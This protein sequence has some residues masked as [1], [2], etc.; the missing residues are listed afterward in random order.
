MPRITP[1]HRT[2]VHDEG[3]WSTVWV[4]GSGR[5]L[6]GSVDECVKV[7]EDGG[8]ALQFVHTYQ[9]HSLGVVSVVA[10]PGAELAAASALDSTVRIW[11]LSS[12]E[13]VSI[14]ETVSTETWSICF[15]PQRDV[16]QLAAAAGTRASVVLWGLLVG[17]NDTEMQA[18]LNLPQVRACGILCLPRWIDR[19]EG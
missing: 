14:I 11:S 16:L 12:H 10:H 7:W 8:E 15:N 18:E 3:V 19:G 5:L 2:E 17:G 6:T 9:G 4:P 13:T 1:V